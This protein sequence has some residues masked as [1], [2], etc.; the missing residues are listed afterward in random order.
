[1][2]LSLEVGKTR[3]AAN[4][5]NELVATSGLRSR[6]TIGVKPFL[7]VRLRPGRVQ[8]VTRVLSG[9]SKLLGR[10]LVALASLL[11]DGVTL[12]GLGD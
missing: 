12:A 2:I 5:G 7:E 4:R 8:P 11:E 10:G 6:E 3:V 1:L 9:L